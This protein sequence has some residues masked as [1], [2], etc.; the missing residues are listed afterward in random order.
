M[1]KGPCSE[2]VAARGTPS[3]DTVAS[4]FS[5]AASGDVVVDR[6][7]GERLRTA[8]GSLGGDHQRPADTALRRRRLT[9][10]LGRPDA[11]AVLGTWLTV[12]LTSCHPRVCAAN[13]ATARPS[14]PVTALAGAAPDIASV[15]GSPAAGLP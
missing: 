3:P 8:H 2:A 4:Y 5:G 9:V 11:E 12:A 14:S 1:G 10:L 7:Q 6:P 13:L 15:T